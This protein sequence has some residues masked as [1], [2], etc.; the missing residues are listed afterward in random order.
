M[1]RSPTPVRPLSRVP[2]PLWLALAAALVLQIAL[3]AL[4]PQTAAS[5]RPL[6]DPPAAGTARIMA[7]GE[8]ELAARMMMLVLQ[9]HD[10][11]PGMSV[12]L[13]QLDYTRV[14]SWLETA[15]A[16]DPSSHYPLLSAVRIYAAV[17]DPARQRQVLDFV[18]R[19][20]LTDPNRRWR[21]L[22]EAAIVAKHRMRDLERALAY[23]KDVTAHAHG[24]HVPAWA[25]DMTVVILEEMGELEAARTLIGGLIHER[26]ITDPNE[27]RYLDQKLKE[28]EALAR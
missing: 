20:F 6:G 26:Q 22:A 16:L 1:I 12:P 25:R 19:A 4:T 8:R 27:L 14:V 10:T 5:Y 18:Q 3:E 28:L 9:A 21:W 15:L 24:A 11:Q 17:P 23:A 13:I 7:F 2:L